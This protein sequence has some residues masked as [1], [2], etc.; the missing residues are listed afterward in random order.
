MTSME[1]ACWWE[2]GVSLLS[3]S[4]VLILLLVVPEVAPAGFAFLALIAFGRVFL[5]QGAKGRIIDER[6]QAI[7]I[8]A[9]HTGVAVAMIVLI[10]GLSVLVA[11]GD[12]PSV[13]KSTL[14]WMV[15]TAFTLSCLVKGLVAVVQYRA[16]HA[17]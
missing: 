4:V 6:D 10:C 2:L 1:K 9:R 13:P 8:G 16:D 12:E 3:L 17:A 7:E 14:V 11:F 15:W 5:T